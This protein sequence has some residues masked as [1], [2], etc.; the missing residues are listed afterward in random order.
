MGIKLFGDFKNI[1]FLMIF[2]FNACTSHFDS[3]PLHEC[4]EDREVASQFL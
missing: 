2:L 4:R 1:V 3:S